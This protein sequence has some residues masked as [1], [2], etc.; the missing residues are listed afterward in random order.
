M[1]SPWRLTPEGIEAKILHILRIYPIISPTMMQAALGP[2]T[3]AILWHPVL[4][5]LINRNLVVR[6]Q[7][8]LLTPAER[9][10]AY[11]KLSL[12]PDEAAA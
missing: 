12:V 5:D 3:K 2:S 8:S 10:N 1:K 9:Y 6:E 7:E 4:Q 11:T